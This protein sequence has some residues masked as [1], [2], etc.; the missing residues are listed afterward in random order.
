MRPLLLLLAVSALLL[1]GCRAD[2]FESSFYYPSRDPFLTPP[3][4][5]DVAIPTPDGL[6]LHG[7]LI[8]PPN[9]PPDAPL[10]A[11]LHAHGNAGNVAGHFACSAF[12]ADHG[13]AVL[14]FDYRSYGRS[15]P[16]PR[17]LRRD[18]LL[19]DTLA[20]LDRLRTLPGIDPG[21]IALFGNS[22]GGVLALAAAAERPDDVRAV[23]SVAAFSGWKSIARRHAGLVGAAVIPA[24]LDAA[25]SIARLGARPVLILHG[26]R[27]EIVPL[28]HAGELD[29]AAH[30][31]G[32]PARLLIAPGAGH[33]DILADD[34]ALQR[35]VAAFVAEALGPRP[36]R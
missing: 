16:S 21:R 11:V 15:A 28:S 32:V 6:T 12:L 29:R 18:D 20:A 22:L 23:V 13:L 35:E 7:W 31:A 33:N 8:R 30:A 25:D 27:D 19:I 1:P 9:A 3:G 14:L 24:G 5:E 2:M 17:R 36:E 26:D 4:V 10:P 34:P